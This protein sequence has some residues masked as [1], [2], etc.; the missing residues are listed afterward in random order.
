MKNFHLLRKILWIILYL[1]ISEILLRI[2][3]IP[4]LNWSGKL[5]NITW[6]LFF[7]KLCPLITYKDC[8]FTFKQAKHSWPI[9]FFVA[10]L[11]IMINLVD[12][13][14]SPTEPVPSNLTELILF[15]L[16]IPGIDEELCFRGILITYLIK[17]FGQRHIYSIILFSS[18]MFALGHAQQANTALLIYCFIYGLG[19]GYLFYKT[20]SLLFPIIWHNLANV[21]SLLL[22]LIV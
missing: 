10:Y 15:E 11:I 2:F 8:G 18:L 5:A 21:S 4:G 7:V 19:F 1:V 9:I 16:T 12:Y 3:N 6:S 20:K 13:Y 22:A 17:V 14:I